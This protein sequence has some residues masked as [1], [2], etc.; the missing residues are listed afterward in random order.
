MIKDVSECELFGD[1]GIII[2]MVLGVLSIMSLLCKPIDFNTL[3]TYVI[4]LIVKRFFEEPKRSWKIFSLVSYIS[5]PSYLM[6]HE[7]H[8]RMYRN[9]HCQH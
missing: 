2:Q 4:L 3:Q 1:F 6:T 7:D 8:Y 5:L 9:K